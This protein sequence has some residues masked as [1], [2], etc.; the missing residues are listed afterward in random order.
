MS[1]YFPDMTLFIAPFFNELTAVD[2]ILLHY[3]N[4]LV[5]ATNQKLLEVNIQTNMNAKRPTLLENIMKIW[6]A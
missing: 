6:T 1:T 4:S 3:V 2:Y 5:Y